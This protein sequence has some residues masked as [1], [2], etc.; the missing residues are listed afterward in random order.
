MAVVIENGAYKGAGGSNGTRG[1]AQ[2]GG[3]KERGVL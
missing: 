3:G 1:D 2:G